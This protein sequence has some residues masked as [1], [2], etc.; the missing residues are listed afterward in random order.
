MPKTNVRLL[1]RT[2][3]HV[4]QH[5]E[6]WDQASWRCRTGMCFAGHALTLKGAKWITG[7]AHEYSEM[8]V[9][10]P[11]EMRVTGPRKPA[12]NGDAPY[13][14]QGV[15]QFFRYRGRW[16][17]GT[18]AEVRAEAILGLTT[19][20]AADLFRGSNTLQELQGQVESLVAD[21]E[22][23]RAAARGK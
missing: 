18:P 5:P 16:V 17:A 20:Q 12:K 11:A 14:T 10:T 7:P 23:E 6:E 2:L 8:L 19:H 9:P 13:Y 1:K 15:V 4:E 3:T 21:A 22:A